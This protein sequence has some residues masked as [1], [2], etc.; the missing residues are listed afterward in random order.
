MHENR[1]EKTF[2][3]KSGGVVLYTSQVKVVIPP[4]CVL[5]HTVMLTLSGWW[6][7]TLPSTVVNKHVGALRNK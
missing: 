5:I 3:F 4:L 2:T 1:T 7:I 6:L